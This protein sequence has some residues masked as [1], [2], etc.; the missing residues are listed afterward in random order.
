M[1]EKLTKNPPGFSLRHLFSRRQKHAADTPAAI[2][3]AKELSKAETAQIS[4]KLNQLQMQIKI[5]REA[6]LHIDVSHRDWNAPRPYA[7]APLLAM[8]PEQYIAWYR[9]PQEIRA[10]EVRDALV[11]IPELVGEISAAI[12]TG[13]V[14]S[15]EVLFQGGRDEHGVL[16]PQLMEA[17]CQPYLLEAKSALKA[18]EDAVPLMTAQYEREAIAYRHFRENLVAAYPDI[19]SQNI[20]KLMYRM[21]NQ[22]LPA[23]NDWGTYFSNPAN[24]K[25]AIQDYARSTQNIVSSDKRTMF[26][27]FFHRPVHIEGRDFC[28]DTSAPASIYTA[29]RNVVTLRNPHADFPPQEALLVPKGQDETLYALKLPEKVA[30]QLAIILAGEAELPHAP[31]HHSSDI[32]SHYRSVATPAQSLADDLETLQSLA[33]GKWAHQHVRVEPH[34]PRVSEQIIRR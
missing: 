16:R 6:A 8:G 2:Y 32:A 9:E 14:L 21:A 10:Q 7:E 20:D 15:K 24:A 26:E 3:G 28:I 30:A 1:P 17:Y 33:K 5:C 27:R 22:V 23:G 18:Y 25:S 29:L 12:G 19:G 31:A 4:E 11:H 34:L 13:M